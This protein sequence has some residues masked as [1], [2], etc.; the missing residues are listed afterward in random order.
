MLRKL[1]LALLFISATSMVGHAQ[2]LE[3][4]MAK[5]KQFEKEMKEPE[6]L[7][8]YKEILKIQ[9]KDVQ[10]LTS[11]SLL[12]SMEGN[13]KKDKSEKLAYFTQAQNY[14]QEAINIDNA[15]ARAYYAAAVATGR[16]GLILG[17]KERVAASR[18]TKKYAEL[19]IKF[20]TTYGEAYYLLGKWNYEVFNMNTVEKAAAKVLF[21][22]M[23]KASLEEAIAN[24]EKCRKLRPGY[25]LNY[26]DLGVALR[27]SGDD[28][29]A[30]EILKKGSSLRPVYFDDI[31][32]RL[33]CKKLVEDM[34]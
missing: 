25:I 30:I 18:D 34:Q 19:A 17:T 23:P 8:Q 12:S 27:Q 31:Q 6:A 32:T 33:N 10:V 16:M 3:D 26:Y 2:S 7:E 13:R 14:A 29:A 22:G 20:D 28:T 24:Y 5:A 11:A 4:M 21:G 1:V 9:P 15:N